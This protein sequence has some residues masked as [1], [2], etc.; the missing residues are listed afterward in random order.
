MSVLCLVAPNADFD[1]DALNGMLILDYRMKKL[2]DRLAPHH[3]V[4]DLKK[5]R[6][7]SKNIKIPAPVT[8]TISA[9]VHEGR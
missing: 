2:L 4:L 3:G 9:W 7:L 8:T 1:G 6:T 5:P